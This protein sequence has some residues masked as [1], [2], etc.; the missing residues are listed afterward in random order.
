M[1]KIETDSAAETRR[2][3]FL[4][5]EALQGGDIV[6]LL[7]DL[8]AGKTVM[9]QGIAE[10][11]GAGRPA[12]S[13]TFSLV[14]QYQG[15]LLIFHLDL[16]RL[17]EPEELEDLGWEEFIGQP[18]VWGKAAAAI[19]EWAEKIIPFL[20]PQYL[21]VSIEWKKEESRV[22]LL[23]GIGE[24]GKELLSRVKTALERQRRAY[25]S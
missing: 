23:E 6:C 1:W 20:P 13:P 24:R 3:G 9:V 22:I 10:G 25:S 14:N 15:R 16:Y 11:A 8:G 2:I 7:G 5:G 21:R 18:Q 12:R 17:Q 19:I 4:I